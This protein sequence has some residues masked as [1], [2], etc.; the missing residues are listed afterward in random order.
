MSLQTV[1]RL[2]RAISGVLALALLVP[3][4]GCSKLKKTFVENQ[5]PTVRLS[6]APVSS[7]GR[8]TY[9][10]RMDWVGYDP[11]GRVDYFLYAKDPKDL[12]HPDSSWVRTERNEEVIEFPAKY[13]DEPIPTKGA[14]AAEPHV[15]AIRAVDNLGTQSETVYRAFFATTAAPIVSVDNPRPREAIEPLVTPSVR[16]NWSGQDPDGP[17]GR[18]VSY[19]FRLFSQ[20][21]PD[22]PTISNFINFATDPATRD[23]FRRLYAPTFG[24]S[25]H[26]PT[27]REWQSSPAET[28]T[29]HYTNLIPSSTYLFVVTGFDAAGAY[30]PI[31]LR[32]KNMLQFNVGYAGSNGPVITMFSSFFFYEYPSGG[33]LN[34]PSR[35]FRVEVPA[36]QFVTFNWFALP[37]AGADIRRYRWVLDLEDLSDETPRRNNQDWYHWS[38]YSLTTTSATIGKFTPPA[39]TTETHAFFIEAEDTNGLKS[40]GIIQFTVVRPTFAKPLLF[41]QDCRLQAD[42]YLLNQPGV[43]KTPSGAWPMKAELDTFFYARGNFPWRGAYP[44]GTLSPPGIFNGY[45]FDTVSV[46]S[47]PTE[48]HRV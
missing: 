38:A 4:A 32:S 21:N 45:V 5:P 28:T 23:S 44:V 9:T 19:R 31:F 29:A 41:V 22:F 17:T 2:P 10:Y 11:D 7:S 3:A 33:Y 18:P 42:Q 35:Y 39:G 8:E 36:D 26:C 20:Q 24:P 6:H 37:P 30:D 1:P 12:N 13:P 16:I 25:D 48:V 46:R 14:T 40:L 34:V 43:Y 15:F 27:C 47:F